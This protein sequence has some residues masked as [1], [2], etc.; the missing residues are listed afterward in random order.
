MKKQSA[1]SFQS[2]NLGVSL[3]KAILNKGYKYPTPIQRKAMP[4]I[5]EGENVVGM[6]R[7]GSGKTASFLIPLISKLGTHSHL[8][9]VRGL[10]ISP[11]RELCLQSAHFFTAFARYTDLRH[12]AI[13]GGTEVDAQFERLSSNPDVIFAT[14]GRLVHHIVRDLTLLGRDRY[15][16]QSG[17]HGSLRRG[18]P[19][20]RDGV[21]RPSENNSEGVAS[22]LL[23]AAPVQR[24]DAGITECV[25][26]DGD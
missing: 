11:T 16:P 20:V 25:C 14:P 12:V 8:V 15:I 2:M 13:V 9:G 23:L 18:R 4:L 5:M 17:E 21:R 3:M 10:V 26:S 19:D 22:F 6:A 1:G 24:D 7:T